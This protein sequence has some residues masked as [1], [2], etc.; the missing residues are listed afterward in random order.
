MMV[1]TDLFATNYD[2]N[3]LKR[4]RPWYWLALLLFVISLFSRQPLLFL[5]ALFIFLVAVVPDLWYRNAFRHL[6]VRQHVNHHNVFFGEEITLSVSIENHKFLPLPWLKVENKIAPP[7]AVLSKKTSR[8]QNARR[9]I[10]VGIW[11]LLAFQKVTRQYSLRCQER[12]FH[13]FGPVNLGSSDPFGWL[14]YEETVPAVE[15][16]VV[17]PLIVPLDALGL[18]TIHPLGEHITAR[19]LL[20]DPL[21]VAGVRDYILGDDPRRIHWKATA[22]AGALRSKVYETPALHRLLLLLDVWN[23]SEA[24]GG[25]DFEIQEL[26]IATAASLG[27]WALEEGYM[28][29]LLANCSM[30]MPL[31]EQVLPMSLPAEETDTIKVDREEFTTSVLS[32]ATTSVPFSSDDGQYERLLS[33]LGRLV[34]QYKGSIGALMDMEESM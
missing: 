8:L 11:L 13:R 14:E 25:T 7:L 18:S 19:R 15:S 29:G 32:P 5:T 16:L 22:R 6:V 3:L 9:E 31:S 12:G 1:N 30:V 10:L 21:R 33:T 23:Y 17:Y 28:V 34:P 27:I 20:E 24:T 4:R 2:K 26:T